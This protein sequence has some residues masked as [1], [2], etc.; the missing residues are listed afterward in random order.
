[1]KILLKQYRIR[2]GMN[3]T[4]LAEEAGIKQQ[5][6]SSIETGQRLPSIFLLM[7]L[8]DVLKVNVKHLWKG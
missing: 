6:I 3:Q 2:A 7:K 8:A 1:M 4:E 5:T